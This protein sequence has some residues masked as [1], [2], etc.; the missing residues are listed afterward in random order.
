MNK[1]T[2]LKSILL[3]CALVVGT[4]SVW[5]EDELHYTL[6]GTTTYS[7]SDYTE[8]H[9]VTQNEMT[10]SVTGNVAQN[11][12]R[13][14]GKNADTVDREVYSKT[15]MDAAIT[16]VDLV[17]GDITL[18]AVNK[19]TLIVANNSDFSTEIQRIEKTQITDN[20]TLTFEPSGSEW[21]TGAYY[22]FVF[23]VTTNSSNKYIHFK[24][25]KFY[26][27]ASTEPAINAEDVVLECEAT[28]GE[29]SYTISNPNGSTFSAAEKSPGYDWIDN[30][31]VDSENS[32]VIFTAEANTGAVREGYITLTYG[33]LSKDIKV[34]Q[35]AYVAK[36]NVT[37]NS[38][39][40]G[41]VTSDKAKAAED[42]TVT[43]TVIP[44][45]GYALSS[46]TV[47]DADDG[48]VA[49]NGTS[50][51]RTFTM[52][53]KAVSID[54]TFE[55]DNSI[56]YDFSFD[57]MGSTGWGGSYA[58]HTQDFG[59]AAVKFSYASKQSGTIT[60]IPVSKGSGSRYV[61]L[62]LK[63][64]NATLKSASFALRHWTNK[65]ITITLYYST[66]GGES[67]TTTGETH[68][69]ASSPTGEDASVTASILPTGTNAVKIEGNVEQQYGI[70]SATVEMLTPA[71]ITTAEYATYCNATNAL[72]FSETGI[73]AYT[74]TDAGIWVTLNEITSGKVPANTPVVLYKAGA[75]GTAINVPVI[76]SA[77][78]PAGT[79][80]LRVSTG[81]D[82]EN[83]YVLS[84]KSGTVGFYKWAGSPALSVGKVYLLASSSSAPDFLGFDGETTAIEAVKAESVESGE[85]F[86][87]A[88][89]RVAQPTKGLYIVNGKKVVVK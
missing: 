89:Q 42:E 65:V 63:D 86:N 54:A 5:A 3:L 29:I 28:S 60:D 40:N 82:V 15:A 12:W 36:Y 69:F 51:T 18:P 6:D 24:S 17:V 20:S 50:N 19:I 84:K 4:S 88:G 77:D 76:A 16:K 11:P 52:P 23:N 73:T 45:A 53:N 68:A 66:D 35:N 70:A 44:D 48:N 72:D 2:F 27:A 75:D 38:M 31:T 58:E 85:Y 25:A 1:V 22:K 78:A 47:T 55:K 79:N 34:S 67:W 41:T 71:I 83:M 80:D 57:S 74:A 7:G 8:P 56:T 81:T 37:I 13:I 10:W 26:K 87:L 30:V 32:K 59:N 9:N 64:V 46:I 21:A 39:T 62:T 49:V 33:S 14:G 61:S 43:L